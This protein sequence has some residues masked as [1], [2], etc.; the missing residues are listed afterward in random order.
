MQAKSITHPD[1]D[2]L[3]A[4]ALGKLE[5]AEVDAVE[6]HLASCD[7]CCD[8]LKQMQED[9][10]V[11]LVRQSKEASQASNAAAAGEV[12]LAAA[13]PSGA[14]QSSVSAAAANADGSQDIPAEL[15]NHTRYRIVGLLGKGGMGEVYKAE[16]RLME[17]MVALKVINPKFVGSKQAVERFRRE[18]QAAARLDHAPIV[19]AHDAEQ[20]GNLHF[21]VM[22]YIE[23]TDLGQALERGP[24]P[25]AEA[26]EYIRQAALG[27]EH[28]HERGMVHRD[29]KPQNLI[30][31]R[32]QDSPSHATIKILDFGIASLSENAAPTINVDE[33]STLDSQK[34]GLTQAG[35]L[36]GTPDYMAPEQGRDASAADNRSDIYSL[37]CT[38]YA[39]L[40]GQVP[41]PGGTADEKILAHVTR[42]ARPLK[43]FRGDVPAALAKVLEKMMAKDP[44]D[45]YQTPAAVARALAPYCRASCLSKFRD[46]LPR[47][48]S[49]VPFAWAAVC[50]GLVALAA[51]VFYVVTDQGTIEIRVEDEKFTNDQI[52]I[53][54]SRNGKTIELR[55]LKTKTNWVLDTGDWTLTLQG[56]P[57]GLAAVVPET[58][59][60]KRGKNTL[61]TISR[62]PER[63]RDIGEIRR[64]EGHGDSVRSLAVSPDGSFMLSGGGE[65]H[66]GDCDLRLWDLNKGTEIRRLEGHTAA[67][68]GL[69]FSP[70]GR[71]ALSSG[72]DRT[73]RLWDIATGKSLARFD[74]APGFVFATAFSPDGR[75]A[76]AGMHAV[77]NTGQLW[78][79]DLETKEVIKRIDAP[80]QIFSVAF[81]PDGRRAFAGDYI[82]KL[83][84]WDLESG[85]ELKRFDGHSGW[86][87]DIALSPDAQQVL[88]A[89]VDR[90]MRLWDVATGNQLKVFQGHKGSVSAV[91]YSPDGRRAATSSRDSTVRIWDLETGLVLN[92]LDAHATDSFKSVAFLPDG[93]HIVATHA[94]GS[95]RLWH[96]TDIAAKHGWTQLFNGKDMTGWKQFGGT[97]CVHGI[98]LLAD[99]ADGGPGK[100]DPEI[101]DALGCGRASVER[102][103]KRFVESLEASL[104]PKPSQRI[105]ERKLDGKAESPLIALVCGAP[106][107]GRSPWTRRLLSDQMVVLDHVESLSHETVR[108]TLKKTNSSLG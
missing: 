26:C 8:A 1:A 14:A 88:T 66:G 75:R 46:R 25:V 67:V 30:L 94:D 61:V 45:R 31:T 22:E 106:P 100:S 78:L 17:R 4:F 85:A 52:K 6:S 74:G 21:L 24:L 55:D 73:V 83:R 23:G 80:G 43:D 108:R 76:L 50:A 71:R 79:L 82:G 90:T 49:Y 37:G 48:R 44:A 34:P 56:D 18:V 101:V 2:Q 54:A 95:I 47:P 93:R 103:R 20:A 98:L 53:V 13:H 35:S 19:R 7:T 91:S 16:H 33:P 41:F 3:N 58:V 62:K 102:I 104:C 38:L 51:T 72:A 92:R 70:D 42:P 10:F 107:E 5:L 99:Q 40:T 65:N 86:I 77:N 69:A 60:L 57:T 96:L 11:G 68:Y 9:T 28:A 39:L 81:L 32:L 36:M 59:T 84:L 89:S 105:F 97:W 87:L 12:T 27:L 29:I 63:P 15:A 64:F